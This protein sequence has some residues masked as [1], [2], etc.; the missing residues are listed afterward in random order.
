[1]HALPQAPQWLGSSLR[2]T[3]RS[4]QNVVPKAQIETHDPA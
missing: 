2:R 3:Q 1:M 4:T